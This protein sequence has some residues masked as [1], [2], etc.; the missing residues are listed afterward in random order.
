[1][2]AFLRTMKMPKRVE[3]WNAYRRP[4]SPKTPAGA[5]FAIGANEGEP[6]LADG[7]STEDALGS[8][9]L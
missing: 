5:L 3:D 8:Q 2:S 1:M 6:T 4:P 9:V 7:R